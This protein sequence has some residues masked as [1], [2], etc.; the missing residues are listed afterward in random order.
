[1]KRLQTDVIVSRR[2]AIVGLGASGIGLALTATDRPSGAQDATVDMATHPIVGT[3]LSGTGPDGL[4]MVHWDADG[5]VDLQSG[6]AP[7]TGAD[8]SIS[9]DDIPM[10]VWE[11]IDDRAI[12]I[13]FSWGTRDATGAI[14]GTTTVDGYPVVSED[15]VSFFDDGTQVVVTL[16]NPQGEVIDTVT[17][18]PPVTGVRSIPGDIGYERVL[19]MIAAQSSNGTPTS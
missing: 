10:G 3:W 11:P 1:M 14:T 17:G 13:T 18:V 8:G 7:I 6:V 4:S 15:G 5:S 12:H 2:T 9:Y 19:G 16:R